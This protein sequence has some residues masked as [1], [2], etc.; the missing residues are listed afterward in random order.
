MWKE[1]N[2]N[3]AHTDPLLIQKTTPNEIQKRKRQN[4]TKKRRKS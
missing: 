2:N 1:W 4:T 3:K